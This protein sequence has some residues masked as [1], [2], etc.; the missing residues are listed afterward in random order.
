MRR[1]NT[2]AIFYRTISKTTLSSS[3]Y[4]LYKPEILRILVP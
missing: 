2:D 4:G 3:G 1:E